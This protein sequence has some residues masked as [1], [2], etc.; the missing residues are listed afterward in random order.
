MQTRVD[1]SAKYTNVVYF[2]LFMHLG[3]V[4]QSSWI[5]QNLNECIIRVDSSQSQGVGF[6]I[7]VR[8]LIKIYDLQRS[9]TV[10]CRF[11]RMTFIPM[12]R[13]MEAVM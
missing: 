5:S 13:S 12:W 9:L 10:M 7:D 6:R 2:P 1:P 3:D 8:C 4:L 11:S